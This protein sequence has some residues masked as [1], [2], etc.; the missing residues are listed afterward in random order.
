MARRGSVKFRDEQLIPSRCPLLGHGL[1]RLKVAGQLVPKGLLR[2]HDQT[3]V[4][5]EGYDAGAKILTAFFKQELEQFRVAELDPL[6][7]AIIDICLND[8]SLND[9]ANILPR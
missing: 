9:Y 8:G 3:E 2:V 4:G 7:K 5:K 6:G 1:E